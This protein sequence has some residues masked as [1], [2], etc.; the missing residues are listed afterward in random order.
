MKTHHS[1]KSIQAVISTKEPRSRQTMHRSGF[2][3]GRRKALKVVI[4]GVATLPLGSILLQRNAY[5]GELEHLSEDDA[6][7]KA[8]NYIHDASNAVADKRKQGTYCKNCNLIQGQEGE[9]RPCSIFPGKLVNE[10]GWC[11]GWVGRV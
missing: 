8:L 11:A 1:S 9:W 4:T 6:T 2:D 7:A 10:N 5:S 3:I